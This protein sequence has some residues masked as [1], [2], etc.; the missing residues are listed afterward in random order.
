MD[1]DEINKLAD[2]IS[3]RLLATNKHPDQQWLIERLKKFYEVH[4]STSNKEI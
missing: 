4:N 1:K 2:E 3:F